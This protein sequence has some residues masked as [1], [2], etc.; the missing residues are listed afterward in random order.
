MRH[1]ALL[2]SALMVGC[3]SFQPNIGTSLSQW[4][5]G[6]QKRSFTQGQLIAAAEDM[7]AY[8][9]QGGSGVAPG[10]I[11]IFQDDVLV[12]ITT[13]TELARLAN[14]RARTAGQIGTNL[15]LLQ[16]LNQ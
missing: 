1:L 9:C 16:H 11:Y 3:A 12:R 8:T 15:L 4:Q 7:K 10:T 14:A 5:S 13:N 6:C 2:L